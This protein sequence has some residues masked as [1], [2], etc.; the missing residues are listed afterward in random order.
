VEISFSRAISY[1]C[2]IE[3]ISPSHPSHAKNKN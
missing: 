1:D 2:Y 3:E